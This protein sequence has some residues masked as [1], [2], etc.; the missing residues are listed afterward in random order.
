MRA[1][2][3]LTFLVALLTFS[4]AASAEPQAEHGIRVVVLDA[5]HGGNDPGAVYGGVKEKDLTLKVVLRLG[6]KIE[7][8]MPGVKVVYTRTTDKALASTK[9]EDLQKRADI[10]NKAEGDLFLSVH[11]NAAK[12]TSAKGVE[13]LIMGETPK[14]QQYNTNAL[15]ESNRDDLLDMS[16][17]KEAAIIRAYIQNLQFTYGEYSTTMARCIQQNYMQAG[18]HSR[19]VKRQPLRV[20]YATNM[21][22]VLTEIG[23]LSNKE[24]AAF[25]KSEKGQTAIVNALYRAVQDYSAYV[26]KMRGAEEPTV[27]EEPKP[28]VKEEPKPAVKEE[29]KPVAKEEK[30]KVE[31]PQLYTPHLYEKHEEKA[32]T[33]KPAAKPAPEAKP[34]PQTQN[35]PAQSTAEPKKQPQ[36][37]ASTPKR[38]YTVQ[39]MAS[40]RTLALSSQEFKSYRNRVHQFESEGVY[41]YKY[42]VGE[43]ATRSEALKALGAVRKSFPQAFVVAVENG[44]TVTQKK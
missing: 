33:A 17:E 40:K 41:R 19:G 14:E 34:A 1:R 26:L 10:A 25:L 44:R 24:E 36:P 23:F 28:A 22:G 4:L 6:K 42:G 37:A 3:I 5:G 30:P 32:S 15:F 21:P 35:K 27:K 2:N 31:T 7:Q 16:N 13:T 20:L 29:P 18:R 39:V 9:I 38:Y 11:V 12:S 43:Y 8:G